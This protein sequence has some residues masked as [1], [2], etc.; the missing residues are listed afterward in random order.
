MFSY[1][2]CPTCSVQW[3]SNPPLPLSKN[4]VTL[5]FLDFSFFCSQTTH[6]SAVLS[7]DSDRTAFLCFHHVFPLPSFACYATVF[8]LFCSS[9]DD[10]NKNTKPNSLLRKLLKNN[11][12]C[13]LIIAGMF[14]YISIRSCS[15]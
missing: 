9:F 14:F 2:H 6:F 8:L 4:P 12:T 5:W 13:P 15:A 7:I 3:C 10:L 11:K 1:R